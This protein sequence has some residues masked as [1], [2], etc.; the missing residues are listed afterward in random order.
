MTEFI[1]WGKWLKLS[2][3]KRWDA[4]QA[5]DRLSYGHVDSWIISAIKYAEAKERAKCIAH[6]RVARS[7]MC[8]KDRAILL[9]EIVKV[10]S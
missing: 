3:K 8:L 2:P 1:G 7:Q 10:D 6:M 5:W 9:E 4:L